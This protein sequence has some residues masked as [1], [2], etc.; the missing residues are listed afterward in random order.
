MGGICHKHIG[1]RNTEIV[2]TIT[3][4]QGLRFASQYSNRK[5]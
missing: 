5:D 1:E 2:L 4:N 3:G